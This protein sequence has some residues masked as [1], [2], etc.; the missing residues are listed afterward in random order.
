MP[1][2]HDVPHSR[3]LISLDDGEAQLLYTRL[4]NDAMDLRHTEVPLSGQGQGLADELVR[5]AL[6]YARG[7]NL[8]IIATCPYVKVWL[9]R[10]PEECAAHI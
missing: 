1:V 8:R 10:H 7:E 3:F 5:A 6:A 2:Q 9:K 4:G